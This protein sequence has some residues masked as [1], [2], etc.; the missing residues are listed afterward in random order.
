MAKRVTPIERPWYRDR[1]QFVRSEDERRW[2]EERE[3]PATVPFEVPKPR[4]VTPEPV[5]LPVVSIPREALIEMARAIPVLPAPEPGPEWPS[6]VDPGQA[7]KFTEHWTGPPEAP[8][9]VL[10]DPAEPVPAPQKSWWRR[11]LRL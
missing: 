3:T 5:V 10:S 8:I 7:V 11:L 1:A 4:D 6:A 2:R 9:R